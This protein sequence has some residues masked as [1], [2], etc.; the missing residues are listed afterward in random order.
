MSIVVNDP[1]N[2]PER[3]IVVYLNKFNNLGISTEFLDSLVKHP[4]NQLG[5]KRDGYYVITTNVSIR[6]NV[7]NNE[8]L[9]LR[10][11]MDECW[12]RGYTYM[13]VKF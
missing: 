2:L 1:A 12:T 4:K 6:S 11:V 10:N 3:I 9:Q 8:L 5:V 7:L 13:M